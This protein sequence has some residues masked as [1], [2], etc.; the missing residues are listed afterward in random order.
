[1]CR[2]FS[3]NTLLI[4]IEYALVTTIWNN[5]YNV[6]VGNNNI[7]TQIGRGPLWLLKPLRES[8]CHFCINVICAIHEECHLYNNNK[9]YLS[10]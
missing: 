6:Y 1:M 7:N 9:K 5:L 8:I 2:T 4:T 10:Q 3:F